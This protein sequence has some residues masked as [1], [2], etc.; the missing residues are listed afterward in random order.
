MLEQTIE[1]APVRR[2]V[3]RLKHGGESCLHLGNLR[4]DHYLSSGLAPQ[5]V[6][7]REVIGVG[8]SLKHI[9]E[10][11]TLVL[12]RGEQPIRRD[13]RQSSGLGLEVE[14]R[15]DERCRFCLRVSHELGDR[16]CGGI[17]ETLD[18]MFDLANFDI[19]RFEASA[20]EVA[21]LLRALSNERRLMILP[22]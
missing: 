13:R 12:D 1:G 18:V 21:K 19:A 3:I 15:V 10:C 2:D 9:S 6:C 14:H 16:R 20:A 4:A 11:Q 17:E 8:V 5:V 7:R 22:S